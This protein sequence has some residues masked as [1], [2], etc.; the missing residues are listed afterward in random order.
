LGLSTRMHAAAEAGGT[1]VTVG[2]YYHFT[3]GRFTAWGRCSKVLV[4]RVAVRGSV[5][6]WI[7]APV[8]AWHCAL[9]CLEKTSGADPD[10]LPPPNPYYPPI[11][12]GNGHNAPPVFSK[13]R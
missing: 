1:E 6:G 3:D 12:P 2:A 11:W 13:G 9:E 8:E 10:P 5:I 7:V 4:P